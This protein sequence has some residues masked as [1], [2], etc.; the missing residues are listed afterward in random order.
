MK[1]IGTLALV[2]Q[3]KKL[4]AGVMK[5]LANQSFTVSDKTCTSQDVVNVL[6]GRISKAQ[7]VEAA[8]AA[9]Q[10]ALKAHREER[11]Q[12]AGF[13]SAFRAIVKGMYSSPETLADFGLSPRKST[14]K[15]LS[16][17]VTAVAKTKATRTARGTKGPKAKAKIKGAA[18]AA[19]PTTKPAPTT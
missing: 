14:K 6:Q 8:R 7:A 10:A 2:E 4:L 17:K 1:S 11:A 13:V 12:T 16:T 5:D 15:T 9:L 3:D 18:P 19:N